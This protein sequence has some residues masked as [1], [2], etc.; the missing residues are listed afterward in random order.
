MVLTNP[1]LLKEKHLKKA[2]YRQLRIHQSARNLGAPSRW[3]EALHRLTSLGGQETSFLSASAIIYLYLCLSIIYDTMTYAYLSL[4]STHLKNI[5]QIGNL[6]QES[7]GENK[8]YLKPPPSCLSI[9]FY[10]STITQ[11]GH[12][13]MACTS[14]WYPA[15]APRHGTTTPSAK[16]PTLCTFKHASI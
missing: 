2:E 10:L 15:L 9:C 5:S 14:V 6:P 11:T 3:R 13:V 12:T 4:V 16:V 7:R 8:A 1:K